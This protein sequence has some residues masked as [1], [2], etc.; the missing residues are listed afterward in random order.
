[1][2]TLLVAGDTMTEKDLLWWGLAAVVA[3]V[4]LRSHPAGAV[5]M[6]RGGR[7]SRSSS[8]GGCGCGQG[9]APILADASESQSQTIG[10][11]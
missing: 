7:A 6:Y 11:F 3:F 5:Q 4:I 1:V 8:T 9:P 2:L 10:G